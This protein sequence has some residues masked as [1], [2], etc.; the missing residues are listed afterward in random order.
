MAPEHR[1]WSAESGALTLGALRIFS[2]NVNGVA[3]F[4]QAY[5]QKSIKVLFKPSPAAG[6]SRRR[7]DSDDDVTTDSDKDEGVD[8]PSRMEDPEKEAKTLLRVALRRYHWPHILFLQ[9]VKIK[10]G[11]TKTMAAVKAAVNDARGSGYSARKDTS[12]KHQIDSTFMST[13]ERDRTPPQDGG[14]VYDVHFSLPTDPRNVKGFGGK[15][16]GVAAIIRQ[17]FARRYVRSIREVP[18]DQEGRIQIVETGEVSFPMAMSSATSVPAQRLWESHTGIAPEQTAP[19]DGARLAIVNI[20]AVNGTDNPYYDAQTGV[21]VGTRH[22][23]KQALHT[24]LLQESH[25]LQRRGFQVIIAGDL[26]VA[27]NEL[28]GYP[29]L[30]TSPHQHVLNRLDFNTKFFTNQVITETLPRAMYSKEGPLHQ[31]ESINGFDGIDTFRHTH[32]SERRYSYYPRNQPWGSSCDRVDLIIASRS[33]A[34][35]VI[36]A[37]ICDNPRDRGP[38]DH[39]PIWVVI[40]PRAGGGERE[41]WGVRWGLNARHESPGGSLA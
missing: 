31:T 37:G 5:Q 34:D 19:E 32:G 7:G 21:K 41:E 20:Y 12:E 38:S 23:R 14:P 30:R 35:S 1:E 8:E 29:N 17:D 36:A 16:Y 10:A 33:L 4:V 18:W 3:P 25:A 28:D 26:N 27:R 11:D 13:Q 40:G 24:E 9:E 15:M 22:D 39:C 2:W 6:K